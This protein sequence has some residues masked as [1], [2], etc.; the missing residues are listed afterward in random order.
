MS[1]VEGGRFP[2]S[3][4]GLNVGPVKFK[5]LLFLSGIAGFAAAGASAGQISKTCSAQSKFGS[6]TIASYSSIDRGG[7]K[8]YCYNVALDSGKTNAITDKTKVGAIYTRNDIFSIF[9]TDVP[10]KF[11][12]KEFDKLKACLQECEFSASKFNLAEI[13]KKRPPTRVAGGG[14]TDSDEGSGGGTA[15]SGKKN[16]EVAANTPAG[17]SQ[18]PAAPAAGSD[19]ANIEKFYAARGEV[20]GKNDHGTYRV[21]EGPNGEAALKY[22][23]GARS[24]QTWQNEARV[25]FNKRSDE[26]TI[27]GS[28]IKYT[29]RK[30]WSEALRKG[31]GSGTV[32]YANGTKVEYENNVPVRKYDAEGKLVSTYKAPAANALKI[33]ACEKSQAIDQSYVC[34]ATYGIAKAT[35]IGNQVLTGAGRMVVTQMGAAASQKAVNGK[36]SGSLDAAAKMAKTSFTYETGLT[37]ANIAA[38]AALNSKAKKHSKNIAELTPMAKSQGVDENYEA[39]KD[40]RGALVEQRDARN[41]AREGAFKATMV[42]MQSLAGA[43]VAKK[44]QKDAERNARDFKKLENQL[45][46]QNFQYDPN[47]LA[48]PGT[49]GEFDPNLLAAT[50]GSGQG[51]LTT[52]DG[53]DPNAPTGPMLG[54]GNDL[55]AGDSTVGAPKAGGFKAGSVAGGAGG[56]GGGA[57]GAGG[58]A[59]GGGGPGAQEESKAA[60]ASEF[61]TKERYE[62]GGGAAGGAKGAGAKGK[63]DVGI[64]LNGLLAQFLPKSE[65]DLGAKNGILD[66]IG[67]G[68]GRNLANEE[69]ASYLD[70]NADLF[71]R[72]HETMSEK[73][74]KGQL[75]I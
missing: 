43:I 7:D 22:T 15:T 33:D 36:M 63:D 48:P 60:Y 61:G 12:F 4:R 56:G 21:V 66:S 50:D 24:G 74:R 20:T 38:A 54:E 59:A 41:T 68:G 58:G 14:T 67:F 53:T 70:K 26:F 47:Q 44:T 25:D 51:N 11:T 52:S 35:D 49:G 39:D 23:S 55:G 13:E 40:Y 2:S 8:H 34:D 5:T 32:T 28:D 30:A 65:E 18:D 72:I 10:G 27:N 3:P 19:A 16:E 17:A 45:A 37:V 71:Q 75:G 42:G 69:P 31:G 1:S 73:N 62:S 57:A 29:D 6:F 9:V 46:A 64:D